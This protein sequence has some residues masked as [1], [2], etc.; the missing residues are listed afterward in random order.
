MNGYLIFE[1]YEAGCSSGDGG[2]GLFVDFFE[3]WFGVAY[4]E[5]L[6]E[7]ESDIGCVCDGIRFLKLLL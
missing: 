6:H 2:V 1:V 3:S 4:F 5:V 7:C